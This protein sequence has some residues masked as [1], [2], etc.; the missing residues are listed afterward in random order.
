MPVVG[1]NLGLVYAYSLPQNANGP[2]PVLC[3]LHGNGECI[4]AGAN[5]DDVRRTVAIHGPL[6][7]GCPPFVRNNF[8]VVYPLLT[9]PGG[10]VWI[11]HVNSVIQIVQEMHNVH[12]GDPARTYL[13][14][15]SYGGNGA[16]DIAAVIRNGINW[17][18]L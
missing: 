15:F 8:I 11:N 12:N 4:A 9:C 3:F 13:S 6:S 14:G 1:R 2:V 7:N 5:D 16:I 17:A 10:D 18:A